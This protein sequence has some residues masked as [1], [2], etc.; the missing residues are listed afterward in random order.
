VGGADIA[1]GTGLRGLCDRVDALDGLLL[2][3]SPPGAGT[4]VTAEIPCAA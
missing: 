3:T 1:T 4:V 2:V